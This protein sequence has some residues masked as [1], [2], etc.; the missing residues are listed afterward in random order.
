MWQILCRLWSQ[1]GTSTIAL[2]IVAL[3]GCAIVGGEAKQPPSTWNVI[4]KA[5]NLDRC[6]T[7]TATFSAH[8]ERD[9]EPWRGAGTKAD[10]REVWDTKIG[11]LARGS[12]YVRIEARPPNDLHII[13]G[14]DGGESEMLAKPGGYEKSVSCENGAFVL[15]LQTHFTGMHSGPIE[16]THR[17]YFIETLDGSLAIRSFV[18]YKA[19]SVFMRLTGFA[20]ED[21]IHD[22][23]FLFPKVTSQ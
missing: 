15:F 13:L 23:W 17:Y 16:E 21:S 7:I 8:G 2:A 14:R 6:P 5:G 4:Q 12:K 10:F 19:T 9:S 11:A 22:N 18:A 1:K 3:H 20:G